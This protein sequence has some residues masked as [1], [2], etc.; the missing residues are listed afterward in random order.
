LSAAEAGHVQRG[1]SHAARAL[2]GLIGVLAFLVIWEAV[3]RAG[4]VDRSYLPPS[5]DVLRRMAHLAVDGEFRLDIAATLAAWASGL[6]IGTVIAV[7]SG[8]LL[9]SLPGVN[10]AVRIL[11]EFLRPIPGVALIPLAILLIPDQAAM[12]RSLVAYA[13]TWPILI[14]TI[15]AVGE[16]DPVALDTARCF[17]LGRLGVL[18]RVALPS[19]A[20]FIATGVRVAAGI[21]L[22]VVVSTELIAGGGQH[23]IGMFIVQ[24]RNAAVD[25]DIVYAGVAYAGLLGYVID[26]VMRLVER[27]LFRWHFARSA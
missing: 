13:T 16:V 1:R 7:P 15:Y 11:V 14:N 26:V 18:I 23:G 25:A 2:R 10:S 17:G 4:I 24:A 12:E 21:G 9:G 3:G 22:I 19:T 5:S 27:R 6:L 20:P 8:L